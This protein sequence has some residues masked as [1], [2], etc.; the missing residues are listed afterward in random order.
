M[1]KF[2]RL[3]LRSPDG[4]E[5][6]LMTGHIAESDDNPHYQIRFDRTISGNDLPDHVTEPSDLLGWTA[7]I[8]TKGMNHPE[9]IPQRGVLTVSGTAQRVRNWNDYWVLIVP[10]HSGPAIP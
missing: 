5:V 3:N 7:V 2:T 9:V 10:T 6:D 8:G 4:E 1:V